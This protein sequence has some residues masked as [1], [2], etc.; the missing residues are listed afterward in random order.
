M[1]ETPAIDR[2]TAGGGGARLGAPGPSRGAPRDASGGDRPAN[3]SGR[4]AI[5]FLQINLDHARVASA[6]LTDAMKEGGFTMALVSDPYRL[7]KKLPKPPS[8]FQY[9]A[10]DNDPAAALLVA[11]A[12]F[13]LCP[14]LITPSVVAVYCEARDLDF[15]L[16]S[17][18]APPHKPMEPILVFVEDAMRASRTRNVVVA[19]DFNAKHSAW[20][21]QPTDA[22]GSRLVAFAAAHGLV[23]LNDP[24]SLPTY[25]TKYSMSSIDVTLASPSLLVG[26]HSW[27]VREDATHSEHRYIAVTIGDSTLTQRKR[28]TTYARAQMLQDIARDSWFVRVTRTEVRS[29]QALDLVLTQFYRVMDAHRRQHLRPVSRSRWGNPWWTPQLAAERRCVNAALCVAY[30]RARDAYLR[31]FCN[32]CSPKSVFSAPYNQAFGKVRVDQV[33]P[34]LI[35]PDGSMTTTHL[36][37]AALLLQTQVAVDD[38]TTD[39]PAH[40]A[41]RSY[42]GAP[43]V[44]QHHDV[45]FTHTELNAVVR[46]MRDSPHGSPISPLLWNVI[47]H[48]LLSLDMPPGV[49]VQA[50]A[51]DTVILI[52]GKTRQSLGE[53]GSEVLRRVEDWTSGAKVRLS[54]EKTF[55]VLFSHGVGGIERVHPTIRAEAS[56]KGLKFVDTLR[57]LRVVFDRRL[58]FFAHADHLRTKAE[59]LAAKITTFKNMAG[60][61]RPSDVRLLY[62]QVVL[63]AIAYASPIWWPERP[64]C[65]LR[66]R[67]M[68]VQRSVLLALTGAYKTTRTAALQLLLHAPPIELELRRLNREFTL[69]VLRQP[70]ECDGHTYAA[71]NVALAIERWTDTRLAR[72]R[73]ARFA[74]FRFSRL[75]QWLGTTASTYIPTDHTRPCPRARRTLS[76]VA[77]RL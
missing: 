39:G 30:L 34:P 62:R 45:P 33:L 68:S 21:Q 31:G 50:Y 77:A 11:R 48:G 3:G 1:D 59:H 12:P 44:T 53:T 52:S 10:A 64:D 41:V 56:G 18:Y 27:C 43:Y 20:G 2:G 67:L 42:V 16:I 47:I 9:I 29:A 7:G 57:V 72:L 22:R 38:P 61:V 15:T 32:E 58:N 54:R 26:G 35:R 5:R 69:F 28:L 17:I 49:S 37:P 6:N 63:P 55:C 19:G 4:T 23:V 24:G 65:R 75:G 51:D 14:L 8:G 46:Q 25:E 60:T 40:R 76:S 36:E 74:G 71:D 66:S 70:V 13:D 73:T